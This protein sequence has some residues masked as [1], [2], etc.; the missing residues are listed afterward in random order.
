MLVSNIHQEKDDFNLTYKFNEILLEKFPGWPW[1][2]RGHRTSNAFT[3]VKDA[4]EGRLQVIGGYTND[5]FKIHY[6]NW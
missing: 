3:S 5:D 6:I 1:T 4:E 2:D